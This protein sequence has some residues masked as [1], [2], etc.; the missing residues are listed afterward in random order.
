M[1][2]Q[3]KQRVVGASVL[4]VLGIIFIPMIL[5][6][7]PSETG[8]AS[9]RA[10][11]AVNPQSQGEGFSSRVVA[12]A[13]LSVP[14]EVS[15]ALTQR[16]N[17][18]NERARAALNKSVTAQRRGQ[19]PPQSPAAVLT[20]PV[21]KRAAKVRVVTGWAVQLGAFLQPANALALRDRLKAKGYP[22]FVE[23]AS[24]GGK[25]VTRVLVGPNRD[26]GRAQTQLETLRKATT[27]SGILVRY[28]KA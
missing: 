1:E 6:G 3:L 28:P 8:D 16:E 23:A 18:P 10:P 4:V 21:Q 14:R 19:L 13:P 25:P 15:S 5:R 24:Q 7:P 20:A 22:A 2:L 11:V 17:S 27:L 9:A 26:R 12:V